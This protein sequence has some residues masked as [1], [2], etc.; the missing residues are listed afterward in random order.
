MTNLGL[1]LFVLCMFEFCSVNKDLE[2]H[3][4]AHKEVSNFWAGED[5][6]ILD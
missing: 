2:I 3:T 5:E 1:Q 6:H 4:P